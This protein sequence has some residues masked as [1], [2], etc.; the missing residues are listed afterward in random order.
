MTPAS[1]CNAEGKLR[2]ERVT[3]MKC[4]K[5]H[6]GLRTVESG[7]WAGRRLAASVSIQISAKSTILSSA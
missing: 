3:L 1:Q 5:E 2:R 4:L 7:D 6:I